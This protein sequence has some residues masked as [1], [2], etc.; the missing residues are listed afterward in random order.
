MCCATFSLQKL[1][2]WIK[3]CFQLETE[4]HV[5]FICWYWG[6]IWLSFEEHFEEKCFNL[7]SSKNAIEIISLSHPP[8][9]NEIAFVRIHAKLL[10]LMPWI[11]LC[12]TFLQIDTDML[13]NCSEKNSRTP[14]KPY[15]CLRGK[16]WIWKSG[17]TRISRTY[18]LHNQIAITHLVQFA[19]LLCDNEADNMWRTRDNVEENEWKRIQTTHRERTFQFIKMIK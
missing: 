4:N 5:A 11:K 12:Y 1:V 19:F 9:Y 14:K 15:T 6:R 18:S 17:F 13:I 8:K 2:C 3:R 10:S 7:I 16:S